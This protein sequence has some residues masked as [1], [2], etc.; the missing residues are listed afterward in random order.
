MTPLRGTARRP[1][2]GR[3]SGRCPPVA[4]GSAACLYSWGRTST[5]AAVP[6]RRVTTEQRRHAGAN[7]FSR[8]LLAPASGGLE[9]WSAAN[10]EERPGWGAAQFEL[11]AV[12]GLMG[13]CVQLDRQSELPP[14]DTNTSTSDL[15][16]PSQHSVFLYHCYVMLFIWV[17]L[18]VRY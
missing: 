4:A 14:S 9:L 6:G 1:T 3:L 10:W 18:A 12:G 13:D 15:W 11:K 8:L 2:R 16:I 5:W 17:W 7:L